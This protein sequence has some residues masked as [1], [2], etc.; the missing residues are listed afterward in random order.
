MKK[1]ST[2]IDIFLYPRST[3]CQEPEQ[4][5]TTI[6]QLVTKKSDNTLS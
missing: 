1:N 2:P 5:I 3:V 6:L 4:N